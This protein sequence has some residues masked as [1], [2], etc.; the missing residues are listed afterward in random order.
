MVLFQPKYEEFGKISRSLHGCGTLI[1]SCGCSAF[2]P[3][4]SISS[5]S[6]RW[7]VVKG[8]PTGL[9]EGQGL[10]MIPDSHG[11]KDAQQIN[12]WTKTFSYNRYFHVWVYQHVQTRSNTPW[13]LSTQEVAWAPLA[14]SS[15]QG[16][17]RPE[18]AFLGYN[19]FRSVCTDSCGDR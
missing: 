16:F 19:L 10:G 9:A 6:L 12:S 2:S 13:I 15:V 8:R 7:S 18:G 3:F 11:T 14:S 1:A 5:N 17:D 4:P